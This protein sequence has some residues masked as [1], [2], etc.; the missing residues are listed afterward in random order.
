MIN[1]VVGKAEDTLMVALLVAEE[2]DQDHLR[3]LLHLILAVSALKYSLN[4][5]LIVRSETTTPA[6]ASED[7]AN[8]S[9]YT[10]L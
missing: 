10:F 1:E 5:I 2:V 7:P 6:K 9:R 4:T 3:D 8:V